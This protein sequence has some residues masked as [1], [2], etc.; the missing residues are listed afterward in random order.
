MQSR[1]WL[2]I[3]LVVGMSL[4]SGYALT[5]LTQA[6]M[7]DYI[8]YSEGARHIVQERDLSN[9]LFLVR[10]PCSRCGLRYWAITRPLY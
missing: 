1:K 5:H 7:G 8:L 3:I 9:S 4:R 10:P 2:F 6:D